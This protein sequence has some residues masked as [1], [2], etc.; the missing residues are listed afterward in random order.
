[1]Q[2]ISAVPGIPEAVSLA[3]MAS[4]STDGTMR[5]SARALEESDFCGCILESRSCA[6]AAKIYK[7]LDAGSAVLLCRLKEHI[8][9]EG[10]MSCTDQK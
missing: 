9:I 3:D 8:N 7:G 2:N 10:A 5:A 1:M 4:L 6:N